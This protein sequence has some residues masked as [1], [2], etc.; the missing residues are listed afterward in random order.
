MLH[1]LGKLE[2]IMTENKEELSVL[3]LVDI[4]NVKTKFTLEIIETLYTS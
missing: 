2:I 3:L 1:H 4:E